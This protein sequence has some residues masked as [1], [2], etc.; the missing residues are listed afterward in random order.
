M[1]ERSACSPVELAGLLTA[2]R[3]RATEQELAVVCRAY[4]L[5]DAAHVGQ[6][7]RSGELYITHPLA[8]AGILTDLNLDAGTIAAALL[9]DVV[10]DTPITLE[11]I[12]AEFGDEVVLMV[13]GVTKLSQR[14]GIRPLNAN[15]EMVSETFEYR[16][17]REAE[18]LRKMMLSVVKDI[19]VVLIK[20]ADRLHNMRTLAVMRQD[21]QRRIARETL[22]IYAPLANRLGIW[23]WKQE[24]EDLGLRYAEPDAY[25][26]IS[27]LL[28][29]GAKERDATIQRYIE[30]VRASLHEFGIDNVEVTGRAKQIYSLWRKMQRKGATFDQIRDTQAIR[31][32]IED[33]ASAVQAAPAAQIEPVR[34]EPVEDEN[35]DD[36]QH[37]ESLRERR[38][39]ARKRLMGDPS[40]Q[41]C[42]TALGVVHRLWPPIPGE[43]DDYIAVPKDNHYQSLHTAVQTKSGMLEVQ[44][45][46]RSMHRSAEFGVAAH[47]LYKD[48]AHLDDNY[49][50]QIEALR[51]AIKSIGTDTED[52]ASFVDALKTEQ[53]I[54]LVFAF[55]PKGKVI[56]LPVGA[57]VLDFAYR[58]HSDIGDRCRGGRVNG[59]MQSVS[60]PVRNGDV[61]DVLTRK[62]PMPSRDWLQG[63]TYCITANAKH[64]IRTFF[65]KQDRDQNIIAGRDIIEREI[66]RMGVSSWMKPA[67]MFRLFK[68]EAGKEDDFLERIG[69]GNITSVSISS[70]IMEEERRRAQERAERITTLG[71]LV[72]L[73]RPRSAPVHAPASGARKG[74]FIVAGVPGLQVQVAQC[75]QPVPGDPVVG[76]VTRG[77]GIRVH[78]RE[79]KNIHNAEQER[80]IEVVYEGASQD[81][82]T[83]QLLVIAA[84]RTGLLG[85]LATALG[86]QQINIIDC[87][88]AKRDLKHGEVQVWI[89]VEVGH[90]SNISVAMSRLKSVRNVFDV[91]RVT[92][93]RR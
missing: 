93:G 8:V 85:E 65:R 86:E 35:G 2:L 55:T 60:Y 75:C 77:Q 40:V 19:R 26:H 9:H 4:E 44:I 13:D 18:S 59:M 50:R 15:G 68:V 52:A 67:D 33:A 70:H 5:A 34:D 12:R 79:C 36:E 1:D 58:I 39:A 74:Q 10:E 42:Y 47:W 29:M 45:R 51:N 92:N 41:A 81:M 22:D 53:L 82:F 28:S 46:T 83:V 24:L 62:E 73:L 54:D 63:N 14:E 32:I 27:N 31:V 56:E 69:F 16:T 76:Y 6:T 78:H 49:Q 38:L 17:E 90:I 11:Q 61:V 66:R 57:T 23:E 64:K 80:L 25:E 43:F 84:E 3:P 88:I 37:A 91:Q 89:K 71:G 20:L 87:S 7:R 30:T 21:K 72:D 48:S